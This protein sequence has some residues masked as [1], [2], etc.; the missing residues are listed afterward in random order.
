MTNSFSPQNLMSDGGGIGKD[1]HMGQLANGMLITVKEHSFFSDMVRK[2]AVRDPKEKEFKSEVRFLGKIRDENVAMLVGFC[3]ED[4][5]R[6]LVYEYVCDGSLEQYL[7][8]KDH[9]SRSVIFNIH[10][11]S[12]LLLDQF[13]QMK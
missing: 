9:L 11:L 10:H 1:I 3:S 8:S 2:H 7:S 13:C 5:H 6:L 12:V 4:G